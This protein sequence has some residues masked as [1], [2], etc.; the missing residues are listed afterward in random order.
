MNLGA[1]QK[2][3]AY[4]PSKECSRCYVCDVGCIWWLTY[5]RTSVLE[6]VTSPDG[7]SPGLGKIGKGGQGEGD[8]LGKDSGGEMNGQQR[9]S[10]KGQGKRTDIKRARR[11]EKE[12]AQ[13]DRN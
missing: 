5:C 9:P 6:W 7:V 8:G 1:G 13:C 2:T 3:G 10:S 12:I 4:F 11:V